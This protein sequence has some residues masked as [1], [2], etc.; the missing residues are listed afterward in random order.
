MILAKNESFQMS[1]QNEINN[2]DFESYFD[3]NINELE[4]KNLVNFLLDKTSRRNSEVDNYCI[5]TIVINV[6]KEVRNKINID[7]Y[8]KAGD[9]LSKLPV[10]N[11]DF[12]LNYNYEKIEHFSINSGTIN[13]L[14]D[15]IGNFTYSYNIKELCYKDSKFIEECW[16]SL[17][18]KHNVYTV[19]KFKIKSL[20]LRL[21]KGPQFFKDLIIKKLKVKEKYAR[22]NKANYTNIL[23]ILT[24]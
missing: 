22:S 18:D 24:N 8:K 7:D 23:S 17:F 16:C 13:M 12:L 6:L 1:L 14:E 20:K 19:D 11:N 2:I 10:L 15:L 3:N 21:N 5:I 4:V 9:I